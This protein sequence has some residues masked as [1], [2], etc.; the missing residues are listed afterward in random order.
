MD[1]HVLTKENTE[2][3]L[4]LRIEGLKQNPEAFSSS[5]EDIINKKGEIGCKAKKIFADENCTLGAF[6]D[7][8]LIGIATL[9]TKPYIKQ[10]HK[11]KIGSVY[12]SPKARGLGVGKAL[13]KECLELAKSLEIEQVMLDVVVGNDGA[14]K[15]YESLGFHTFGIQERALKYNGQYW[16]EEHMVIF[17]DENK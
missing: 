14:K 5:Y 13:I 9:E 17:L 12:V 11:A 1:I 7:G 10:E 15:L 8:K 6:K 16:D 4:E 2:I 3:Y